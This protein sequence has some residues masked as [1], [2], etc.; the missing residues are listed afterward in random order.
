M[1][2]NLKQITAEEWHKL[3][4]LP[5]C[6]R[7]NHRGYCQLYLS[8]RPV[9]ESRYVGNQTKFYTY[10]GALEDIATHAED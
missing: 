3:A 9:A 1:V 7:Y 2:D 6:H 5:G 8:G 10:D 4:A